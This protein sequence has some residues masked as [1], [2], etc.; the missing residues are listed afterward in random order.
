[1]HDQTRVLR[2]PTLR[3]AGGNPVFAAGK[4]L[5]PAVSRW[6]ADKARRRL[7][8]DD[9]GTLRHFGGV[10][11]G[12]N[13]PRKYLFDRRVTRGAFEFQGDFI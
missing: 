1:M 8:E 4:G 13:D 5:E 7:C 9:G 10:P 11:F 3:R 12:K 6:G 2:S